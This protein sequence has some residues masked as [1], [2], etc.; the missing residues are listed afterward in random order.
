[1]ILCIIFLIIILIYS[2]NKIY[3]YTVNIRINVHI[4]KRQKILLELYNILIES[5][6]L[7]KTKPFLLYGTLLGYIRNKD[8]ICYDFDIDI[9]ILTEEFDILSKDIISLVNSKYKNYKVRNKNIFGYRHLEI[10]HKET[11]LNLDLSEF[12]IN[13]N[14]IYRNVPQI[15]SI[16]YD[17]PI[18]KQPIDVYLPL[19]EI[20]FK[21][22]KIYI[23]N[24]S[25][26]ILQCTYGSD[27]LIPNHTCNDDCSVCKK[28]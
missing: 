4:N 23:P 13:N 21:N 11:L 10:I 24:Q 2:Y 26:K 16:F 7:S 27:Y 6:Q 25:E 15:Y 17:C 3:N 19:K 12:I 8:F 20:M 5:S 14:K 22:H 1:M 18:Y 28:I 9:G